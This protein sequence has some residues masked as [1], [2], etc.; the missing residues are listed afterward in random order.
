[1]P[2]YSLRHDAVGLVLVRWKDAREAT[3]G[4]YFGFQYIVGM[5]SAIY[6][7]F[8]LVLLAAGIFPTI[9]NIVFSA[10]ELRP[11]DLLA[12]LLGIVTCAIGIGMPV[13]SQYRSRLVPREFVDFRFQLLMVLNPF[14]SFV[15]AGVRLNLEGL[16]ELEKK[17]GI[18]TVYVNNAFR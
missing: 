3:R 4:V 13:L 1:M 18:P 8:G 12:T 11:P 14:F 10:P 2:C 6:F 16:K 9:K 15:P 7:S 5:A 17:P